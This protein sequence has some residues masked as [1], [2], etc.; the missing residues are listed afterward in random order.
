[1]PRSDHT[2]DAAT[3]RWFRESA[4][5]GI[6]T[7]DAALHIVGWNRWL[8]AVTG[9]TEE[10]AVG[11]SIL[12]VLP[13]FV[14][15]GFDQYYNDAL[16]GIVTVLSYAL[17]RFILPA[18]LDGPDE[19][20]SP[21]R[22][23]ISPLWNGDDVVGTITIIEDVSERVATERELRAQIAT[24]EA[25]RKTAEAASRVKDEFLATLSHEI[26]TPLNA[27]LGWTRI[28]KSRDLDDSTR[29]RAIEV[30]DRNAAAQLTL[31]SDLLDMSRIAAGK[32]RL[33]VDAVDLEP[34]ALAAVDVIRPAADAKGVRLVTAVAH[35]PPVSGDGDRLSQV[36]WNLLSNAVKFTDPGGVVTVT[37]EARAG[38]VLLIVT[39]TGQGID[40]VF[41]PHVFERFTQSDSSAS[42]RHGGLGLGLALV[43]E[44]V[45]LHGGTVRVASDGTGKGTT[46]TVVLPA[47]LERMLATGSVVRESP[48]RPSNLEG[49][50]V[51]IVEDEEDARD[52]ISRSMREFG[53]QVTPVS[54]AAEALAFLDGCATPE[55]PHVVVTDIGMP[56]QDG[57]SLLEQ[58]RRLPPEHGGG[59][60]AVAVTAYA[61]PADR[62]RVLAAGFKLH[63]EKP[64][65]P[66]ALAAAVA[67]V[68]SG[69]V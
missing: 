47:R 16:N 51:L 69:T 34:V 41:L 14:E 25:A 48:E 3:L 43:R 23:R 61:G 58:I 5:G 45:E 18:R 42:R 9:I 1:M 13:S 33:E 15:R 28:L 4:S 38:E 44:L 2:I 6:V 55:L 19:Q 36:I 30:I 12:T 50:R 39:D 22:G 54:S 60:P 68:A 62:E 24:S 46:F 27:V 65:A 64:V 11:R 32:L 53:A 59:L 56:D 66:L 67:R 7:T 10:N 49:I 37:L 20:P 40:A 8:V 63:I 26:R 21:Q 35:V 57:Y 17:H 29:Q 52:I 31:V